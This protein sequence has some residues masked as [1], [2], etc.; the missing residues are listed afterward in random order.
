MRATQAERVGAASVALDRKID[1]LCAHRR[2]L[3]DLLLD[4]SDPDPQRLRKSAMRVR[5][6]TRLR[7]IH[8][9]L[10]LFERKAEV[11]RSAEQMNALDR[12]F[13]EEPVAVLAA[14][15]RTQKPD[16]GVKPDSASGHLSLFGDSA[17]SEENLCLRHGGDAT[18]HR[19]TVAPH[20]ARLNLPL[21]LSAGV[22]R[23]L[24]RPDAHSA[25]ATFDRRLSA[26]LSGAVSTAPWLGTDDL[27]RDT[28]TECGIPPAVARYPSPDMSTKDELDRWRVDLAA[29][30]IPQHILDQAPASPWTPE[31]A[32]EALPLGGSVLDIGAGAGAASLP[33]LDRAGALIAVDQDEPLLVEL[34]KQ[35]GA[36]RDKVRTI[37]GTWPDLAGDVGPANVVVCHHVLYNVPELKPFIDALDAHARSRVVI[38]V[39]AQHPLARLNPLWARFHGLERPTR[40]TWEDALRTIRSFHKDVHVERSPASTTPAFG[41]WQELV[42][43]TTRRLCL[44]FERQ[45]E[46]ADALTEL[47]AVASDPSTWSGSNREVMTLWWNVA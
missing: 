40:P 17:H 25:I 9:V 34:T 8:H 42:G 3:A 38:E 28:F 33:L 32:C 46:V 22:G 36:E 13:A 27:G 20:R 5:A 39:T 35:A 14:S 47:G 45:A 31:R 4:G 30:A 26:G 37:V 41:S 24:A 15:D 23:L 19:R 44:P 29:W 12:V 18:R 16:V 43:A 11:H 1:Q 21:P 10:D 2:Q 7:D 6:V